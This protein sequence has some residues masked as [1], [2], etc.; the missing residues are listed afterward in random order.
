M[1]VE[2]LS[3]SIRQHMVRDI[4]KENGIIQNHEKV[5][6]F[7]TN[8]IKSHLTN[9]E[10]LVV[11]TDILKLREYIEVTYNLLISLHKRYIN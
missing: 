4:N 3:K 10:D 9:N 1:H 5:S 2:W 6:R 8:H 11:Y 7:T